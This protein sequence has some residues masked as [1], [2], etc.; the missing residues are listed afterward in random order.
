MRHVPIRSTSTIY[1]MI[2]GLS[3]DMTNRLMEIYFRSY[4]SNSYK[5]NIFFISEEI[6]NNNPDLYNKIRSK[7]QGE[8]YFWN[9]W[10]TD[11]VLVD[12][13]LLSINVKWS[14]HN[15]YLTERG[16]I[17]S[18]LVTWIYITK[19]Q[20]NIIGISKIRKGVICES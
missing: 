13:G 18:K 8:F 12:R 7:K 16:F 9:C 1:K 20:N 10:A 19:L 14:N 11:K 3:R 2:K 17:I 15:Y 5:K 6:D 4:F